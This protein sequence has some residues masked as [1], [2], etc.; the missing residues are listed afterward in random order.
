M[1]GYEYTTFKL[2][3]AYVAGMMMIAAE[4]RE[5]RPHWA[6][7]FTVRDTDETARTAVKLGAE[8]VVPPQD[9]PGI[10]RFC[11]I[12][13]PQGVGFYAIKYAQ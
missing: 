10:G 1:P 12:T 2:G 6:T 9:I 3:T 5:V 13:S 11:S 7:Y 8:L 4:Q